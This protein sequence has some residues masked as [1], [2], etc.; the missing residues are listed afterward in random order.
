MNQILTIGGRQFRSY[1]NG[2]VAYIVICIVMLTLGFF[3]WNTF[4][5]FGRASTREMFRWLGLILVFA[6]PALT[7]GLLAEEK[8]TGTIELLITM[9]VTEAQVILGKFLGVLG[10]YAVLLVLTLAYPISV[11]TLGNLDWG[12]VWSG[13][14]GLFLQGSAVLAIGL[15]A[16]SWTSNQLIA[17]FVAMTLS[18]FLWV[19]DKF[20]ALLPTNAASAIEWLSFDYHFQS[21]ARGVIDL[22]DVFF[23][24]SVT[25]FALALAFRALESRRWS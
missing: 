15:M 23:F 19:L 25:L 14:L 11:S 7:M 16:S 5:L 13:Y 21:M 9:P 20:L 1:F 22:R 18:V 6:L 17:L 12:P 4:F 10:L 8:R 24:F 2:P 3:F